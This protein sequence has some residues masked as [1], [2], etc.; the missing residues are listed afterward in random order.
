LS[1]SNLTGKLPI[2]IIY[3]A[4]GDQGLFLKKPPLD[5][6]KTFYK[7]RRG[8]S[9]SFIASTIF[10]AVIGMD[11]MRIP[12]A[13]STALATIGAIGIMVCSPI[14]R[15]PNGPSGCGTSI[16]IARKEAWHV[17]HGRAAG[18]TFLNGP[19]N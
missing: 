7:K 16:I 4:F 19:G 6:A 18:G 15:A 13:S 12:M 11:L 2:R 1:T 9:F 14:P 5:P 3:Y 17:R 8:Y 10:S